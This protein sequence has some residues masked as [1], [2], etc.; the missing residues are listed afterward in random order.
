MSG[1]ASQRRTRRRLALAAALLPLLPIDAGAKPKDVP[2]SV[3]I[4]PELPVARPDFPQPSDPNILFF[5]QRSM[6]ANTVV[7]AAAPQ[8]GPLDCGK[9][10]KVFWRR[11]NSGGERLPLSFLE[12]TMAFGVKT[13]RSSVSGE[14]EARI[15]AAPDRKV[16]LRRKADGGWEISARIGGRLATPIYAYVEVNESGMIPSV[17]RIRLYGVDKA[18]GRAIVET[19]KVTGQ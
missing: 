11:F 17:E 9:P 15:A 7:Y 1:G 19:V 4:L 14:C 16:T 13:R 12:R 6:N 18:S 3:E 2:E 5:I 8:S 10:V